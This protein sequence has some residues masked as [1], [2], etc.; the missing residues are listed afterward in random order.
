MLLSSF[1]SSSSLLVCIS[2]MLGVRLLWGIEKRYKKLAYRL[3]SWLGILIL[4]LHNDWFSIYWFYTFLFVVWS[5]LLVSLELVCTFNALSFTVNVFKRNYPK[6]EYAQQC[7][8]F[9]NNLMIGL[10]NR[11]CIS[12]NSGET[13]SH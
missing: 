9:L 11:L 13:R 8:C 7:L 10:F 1:T 6:L 2:W 5:V 4:R 12:T 3:R